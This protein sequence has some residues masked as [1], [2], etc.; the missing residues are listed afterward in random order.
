MHRCADI[1]RQVLNFCIMIS[2]Y[3]G[4]LSSYLTRYGICLRQ[5]SERSIRH[6]A[7]GMQLEAACAQHSAHIKLHE[8]WRPIFC[9]LFLA[10][11]LAIDHGYI[12]INHRSLIVHCCCSSRASRMLKLIHFIRVDAAQLAGKCLS[13]K[14]HV[15]GIYLRMKSRYFGANFQ[16]PFTS[17]DGA[18]NLVTVHAWRECLQGA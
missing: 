16:A 7:P 17:H 18:D 1:I 6:K 2:M 4:S 8:A 11:L 10:C 3:A 15:A 12:V 14:P 13:S 9:A 5:L